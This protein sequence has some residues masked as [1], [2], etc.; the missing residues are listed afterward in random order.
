MTSLI[1]YRYS[2]LMSS[3]SPSDEDTFMKMYLPDNSSSTRNDA[4]FVVDTDIEGIIST[5]DEETTVTGDKNSEE[6][7][8]KTSSGENMFVVYHHLYKIVS[9]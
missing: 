1:S 8:D 7:E 6:R 9:G 3:C 2:Q 4:T 5:G